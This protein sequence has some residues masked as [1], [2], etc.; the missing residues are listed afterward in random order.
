MEYKLNNTNLYANIT[1][2][3]RPVLFSD[4]T[5]PA[6]TD[7]IDPN[8]KDASGFNAD[9]GYRGTVGNYLNFDI[10]L[11]YLSY[12]NRIGGVRQFLNN[13]PSQGTFLFRTNL[14]ETINKGIESF[15][16][17]NISKFLKIDKTIG[18]LDAFATMSFIDSRYTDFKIF[19][20]NGT[21]PNIE[22]TERNLDGNRIE[23]APRYIH[24]FGL[25]WQK[26]GFSTTLQYRMTGRIFTD[27]NNTFEASSNGVTGMLDGYNVVD[28][29]TEYLFLK[30]Y[31]IRAGIN[32]LTNEVYATRRATGYPGPGILP[33]EGTTFFISIG[34]KF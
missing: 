24:N 9:I 3:Y 16:N 25:G 29:S 5:P 19:S 27:A 33:G 31:N 7:V 10:G 13:D 26:N 32:N 17:F 1:Q 22:I 21:A 8:L 14:G 18:S 34:A 12:N 15:V 6:V 4:L 2:A 30:N 11:F 20:T 23:N 28:L